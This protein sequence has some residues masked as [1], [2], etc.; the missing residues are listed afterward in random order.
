MGNPF[1]ICKPA[2]LE[3]KVGNLLKREL[4]YNSDNL[5]KASHS[6]TSAIS[7]YNLTVSRSAPC[8]RIK[9]SSPIMIPVSRSGLLPLKI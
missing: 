7:N 5:L 8:E 9:P 6:K 4:Y 1:S 3:A 2:N